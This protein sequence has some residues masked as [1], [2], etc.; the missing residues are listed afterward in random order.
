MAYQY[1]DA[2]HQK[3]IASGQERQPAR[4]K[5]PL[6]RFAAKVTRPGKL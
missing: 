1:N 4:D 6:H 2:E 5:T 3:S